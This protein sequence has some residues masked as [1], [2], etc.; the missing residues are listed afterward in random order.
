MKITL[1]LTGLHH[2]VRLY[3]TKGTTPLTGEVGRGLKKLTVLGMMCLC[4]TVQQSRWT[5]QSNFAPIWRVLQEAKSDRAIFASMIAPDRA[6]AVGHVNRR[7]APDEEPCWKACA[8][9]RT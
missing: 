1:N 9:R 5:R 2:F 4:K 8:S 7:L 6:I 3:L